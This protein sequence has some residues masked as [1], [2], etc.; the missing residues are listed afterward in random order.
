MRALPNEQQAEA[1]FR[2]ALDIARYQQAKSLEPRTAMS[3]G[4]LWQRHGKTDRARQML[5]GVYA[6]FI[7]GFDTADLKEAQAL[8]EQWA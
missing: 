5:T 4:R 3:L 1:C 6:W 8:L 7:E 2:Q